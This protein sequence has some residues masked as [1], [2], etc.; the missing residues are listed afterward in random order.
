MS[1][2]KHTTLGQMRDFAER[3]DARDDDQE[4]LLDQ[5]L[6]KLN[7]VERGAN[8]YTH[9]S[10]TAR[11]AGLYKVTVDAS[12]HVSA[13]AVVTKSDITALGIPAQ[14]TTY[15]AMSGATSSA[16][17][18]AGLV[19]APAAGKQT[20]FLRGDGT[21]VIP[22]NTTY[23]AATTSAAGLMSAA[24][25]SKL[26]GIATGANKYT[27]P[28]YTAKNSGLYKITVDATGHVSGVAAVAKSDITALGIPAQDTTYAAATTS[29]S[30]L[31]SA[32]DKSKLDGITAGANK[33]TH[34]AYTARTGVP[35]ANANLSFGGT[36][37]V[38]QP[39]SDATGH[40]TAINSRTYTM[41]SDRLFTT[42][43][44]TGTAI[45]ANANLNTT[46]YLKVGRYYC[47][48]NA[49]AATLKNCP[50]STA[51]MMEVYSPLSTTIDNETTGT[52]V[53]RLRKITHYNTGKQYIQ[54]CSA[55][56]TAGTWT[57]GSWNVVPITPFTMDSADSN[58]GNAT[59][60]SANKPVYVNDG[61]LY[62]ANTY[63]GGT[64][65]TL[66]NSSK[67][68]STASFYAPTAGGTSG[69]V[70]V[71]NG[72][73]SAPV[74]KSL[75]DAG[76]SP[77]HNHNYLPL[78]GGTVTGGVT[79]NASIYM[80]GGVLINSYN[81]DGSVC[82]MINVNASS[83]DLNLGVSNYPHSGDTNISAPNG[84]VYIKNSGHGLRFIEYSGNF[85]A[86]FTPNDQNGTIACGSTG[87][88][89]FRV[90]ANSTT[91]AASDER[92]K[93]DIMAIA[94][95]PVMF[96]A[97]AEGNIWEQIFS[98]LTPKTYTLNVEKTNDI[99]IGFI[100]QDIEK[101][102]DEFGLTTDDLGLIVHDYWTDEKTGEEKDGYGLAYEE[103]IALNTY[104]IQKQQAKIRYL[105]E[106][107]E[108]LAGNV[109]GKEV[110]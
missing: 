77:T 49:N 94:D 25:K 71:G 99:H 41:P 66:N 87:Y 103:F 27:H 93:S 98:K 29:A 80:K 95:Y 7:T 64:A 69:Q 9:P 68:G 26:D 84:N 97:D 35:T 59:L 55:G 48:S 28:S 21:W 104:M 58:G 52:W 38:S 70:L 17:G 39:V 33:Y 5:I 4:T 6:E 46:D 102:L 12:G 65:V 81:P 24:D 3:Q 56:S 82:G 15:S 37:T 19:P 96:A 18:K 79:H 44:P 106:K 22:T 20:A 108:K 83:G 14:D 75:A 100:A 31:M 32:S 61:V 72:T 11:T 86:M 67:A 60:G 42:L 47:S 73:T 10:Y 34:P 57:Y 30:G 2:N 23:S 85:D 8:K 53:Y 74:W 101:V 62:A 88:P 90:Y 91:I 76:I 1:E 43:V 63:A 40:V 50:L 107:I 16:A 89:W 92:V 45:P 13:V 110:A 36:F 105:E 51:F 109:D 54:Y 78:S